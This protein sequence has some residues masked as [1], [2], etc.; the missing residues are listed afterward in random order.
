[1]A[2]L[3]A[4]VAF[5]SCENSDI[6]FGD[7]SY[8]T[9]Y[10]SSQSPIRTIT[11]GEDVY[12]T[13]LDN[14]H[15][16]QIY[17][18]LGGVEKNKSRRTINIAVDERLCDNLQ[19]E[20]GSPVRPLPSEYYRLSGNTITINSGEITNCVDIQLTDAFFNDPMATKLAYVLPVRMV[21]ASDSI[22]SGKPKSGVAN[23]N[24]ANPAHWDMQP[25]NYTLYALK[26]KNKYH[27]C[28]LSKGTDVITTGGEA[29][30]NERIP[31][32]WE[33]AGLVYLT[34]KGL[35]QS[36]YNVSV[37]V[38]TLDA[39][40]KPTVATKTC[41]LILSFDN[42]GNCAVATDTEGCMASGTGK[43]TYH[44]EPQ[45][46]NKADRDRLKLDYTVTFAYKS[47]ADDVVTILKT[48]ETLVMRD[49]Q[50]KFES[51]S[52]TIK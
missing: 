28:W 15:R 4:L 23:P 5:S 36:Y 3:G 9:V 6:E 41:R 32:D 13:E 16:F 45:A 17:A 29:T 39:A 34:T 44:G 1:M 19:F 14:R 42:D 22:L 48:T 12:S 43:W 50:S 49:R 35:Q 30:T 10:F 20:D 31:A 52:Y 33:D 24:V 2:A 27:G 25:K 26:Y 21:S 8:Q 37:N 46:W 7:F 38:N 51:F 18:R 11:L 47:G 40:G